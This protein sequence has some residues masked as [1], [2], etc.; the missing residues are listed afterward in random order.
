MGEGRERAIEVEVEVEGVVEPLTRVRTLHP[1]QNRRTSWTDGH[2]DI[3]WSRKRTGEWG[4]SGE[5]D[6]TERESGGGAG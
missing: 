3:R 1:Q 4:G 5:D 2:S 6:N